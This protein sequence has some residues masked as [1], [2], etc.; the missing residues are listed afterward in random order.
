[1]ADET[2]AAEAHRRF[3][4]DSRELSVPQLIRQILKPLASMKLTVILFALA[5]FLVFTGTLVQ[6]RHGIWKVMDMYFRSCFAWIEFKI[7]FPP[8]WVPGLVSKEW[9]PFFLE[10]NGVM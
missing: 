4:A 6:T 3:T 8:A 5:V 9:Q 1:M 7:F 2:P 10:K